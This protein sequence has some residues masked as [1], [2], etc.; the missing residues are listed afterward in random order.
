MIDRICDVIEYIASFLID[1]GSAIAE[2]LSQITQLAIG[3]IY[4][5]S[6]LGAQATELKS[7]FIDKGGKSP[8]RHVRFSQELPTVRIIPNRFTDNADHESQG[9]GRH[10]L[11]EWAYKR[12]E[13][14]AF[15]ERVQYFMENPDKI[16]STEAAVDA[17][18]FLE[19]LKNPQEFNDQAF[20]TRRK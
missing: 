7:C 8:N 9:L 17:K 11:E 10:I 16:D 15:N 20:K 1:T 12:G 5:P 4:R 3:L 18:D 2:R 14:T 13:R 19:M 6:N